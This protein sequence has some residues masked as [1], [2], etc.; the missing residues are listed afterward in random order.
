MVAWAG[1]GTRV[2][3]RM[4]LWRKG[5]LRREW[6]KAKVQRGRLPGETA[7]EK[8]RRGTNLSECG[9]ESAHVEVPV[10]SESH[11]RAGF[12]SAPVTATAAFIATF[13]SRFTAASCVTSGSC[14]HRGEDDGALG[15][16]NDRGLAG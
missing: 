5:W 6:A 11:L 10:R 13:T 8:R 4:S 15:D 14:R 9:L 1:T 3:V 16:R 12:A 7:G 2:E